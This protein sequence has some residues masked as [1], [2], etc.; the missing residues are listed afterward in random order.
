MNDAEREESR[1]TIAALAGRRE[2][3]HGTPLRYGCRRCDDEAAQWLQLRR[4]VV[5]AAISNTV[6][7]EQLGRMLRRYLGLPD[8]PP[9][10]AE[11]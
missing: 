11:S 2:C 9:F 5:G 1:R 3:E 4:Q 7:H 6:T 8:E 10:T